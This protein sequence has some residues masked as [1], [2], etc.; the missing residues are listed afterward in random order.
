MIEPPAEPEPNLTPPDPL[1]AFE[2]ALT[3]AISFPLTK[4]FWIVSLVNSSVADP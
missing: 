2:T 3:V 4:S 1:K